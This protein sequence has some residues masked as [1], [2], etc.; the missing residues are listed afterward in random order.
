MRKALA[1][2]GGNT[3]EHI[4]LDDEIVSDI[5]VRA[6]VLR[7]IPADALEDL[8]LR[9]VKPLMTAEEAL[10]VDLEIDVMIE[11]GAP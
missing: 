6:P 11:E 1:L 9:R 8:V 5:L 7:K 4:E 3:F 2:I 10:Q